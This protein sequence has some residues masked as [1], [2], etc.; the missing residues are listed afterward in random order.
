[1]VEKGGLKYQG[2]SH[3]VTENKGRANRQIGWS[4][5]VDE[6]KQLNFL[7]HDIYENKGT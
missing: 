4:H 1:M 7:G 5:D 2:R 3:D 6:N